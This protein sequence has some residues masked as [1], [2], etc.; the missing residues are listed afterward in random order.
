MPAGGP[1]GGPHTLGQVIIPAGSPDQVCAAGPRLWTDR[2]VG[3]IDLGNVGRI[4][5]VLFSRSSRQRLGALPAHAPL[6]REPRVLAAWLVRECWGAYLAILG[7]PGSG[8]FQVLADPSGLLPVYLFETAAHVLLTSHPAL[9]SDATRKPMRPS[10][11]A[12]HAHLCRP[13]L[14][15]RATCLDGVSELAPG[16]LVPLMGQSRSPVTCS[17]HA[18]RSWVV[19]WC[20][21]SPA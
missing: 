10:W 12:L 7:E 14:R 6:D 9:F 2:G 13:E 19:R 3:V 8:G 20:S 15:Q 4:L 21:K 11:P 16:T 17:C 18:A 1:P 5:G